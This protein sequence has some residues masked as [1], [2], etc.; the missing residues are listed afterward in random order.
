M[1]VMAIWNFRTVQPPTDPNQAGNPTRGFS[2]VNF[3][4]SP[5]PAYTLLQREAPNLQRAFTG[6]HRADSPL[7]Q[8]SS[9][10]SLNGSGDATTLVAQTDGAQATIDFSGTRLDLLLSGN[11]GSLRVALDGG[12]TRTISAPGVPKRVTVADGLSDGPHQ[13][14]V[15]AT[16]GGAQATSIGGFVVVRR[17]INSWIYPWIY[18]T[19]ALLLLL[20]LASLGWAIRRAREPAAALPDINHVFSARD[21]RDARRPTRHP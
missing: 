9:G 4:F 11:S 10:W 21:L 20:N 15:T 17:T 8:H 13:A 7:I 6:A 2:I 5:T 18:A 12:H 14:V 3:D 1:G 19:L 16:A